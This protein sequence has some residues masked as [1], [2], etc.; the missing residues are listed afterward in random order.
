MDLLARGFAITQAKPDGLDD[1][2]IANLPWLIMLAVGFVLVVAAIYIQNFSL[3]GILGILM[4]SGGMFVFA[5]EDAVL[6]LAM[7]MISI[8]LLRVILSVSIWSAMNGWSAHLKLALK[9]VSTQEASESDLSLFV[10]KEGQATTALRPAGI[11]E[12]DGVRLSIGTIGGYIGAGDPVVVDR[13]EGNLIV[14]KSRCARTSA[15]SR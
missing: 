13:V 10:G 9:E 6:G 14:V 3:P 5:Q 1:M 8:A 11:G 4:L 2:I 12:F 15:I 7:M